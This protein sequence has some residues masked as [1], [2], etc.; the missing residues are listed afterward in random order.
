MKN[1]NCDNDK[2]VRPNGEVRVLPLGGGANLIVCEV[3]YDH[4]MRYRRGRNLYDAHKFDLPM[5]DQLEVY[6]VEEV[7]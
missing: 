6:R 1:P 7:S 4:E 5:W 3:C 2:C